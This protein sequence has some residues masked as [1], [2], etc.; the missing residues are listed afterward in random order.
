MR[1]VRTER[2]KYIRFFEKLTHYPV[3]GDIVDSG[4]SLELGRTERSGYE[5][6]YDLVNDP[7]ERVDLSS[8]GDYGSI[9][10]ELRDMLASWMLETEDPL[11][12]GPVGS[13]FYNRSVAEL[14]AS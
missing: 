6:L 12:L 10:L 13:P 3:P 14:R 2:Y 5:V 1:C 4:A 7:D 11:L 8:D 9:V